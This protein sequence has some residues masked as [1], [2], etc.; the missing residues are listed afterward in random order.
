MVQ[1]VGA[2]TFILWYYMDDT[3]TVLILKTAAA[4]STLIHSFHT[5][6]H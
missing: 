3:N 6:G 1:P 4:Q 2:L 5:F